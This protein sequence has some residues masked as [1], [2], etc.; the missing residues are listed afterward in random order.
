MRTSGTIEPIRGG[1]QMAAFKPDRVCDF[2]WCETVLS[3]YNAEPS[4]WQHREALTEQRRTATPRG[5]TALPLFRSNISAGSA[6][7]AH[8]DDRRS[9]IQD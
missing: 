4:C 1:K 7:A 8:A 6:S 9:G 3:R 5:S 2:P